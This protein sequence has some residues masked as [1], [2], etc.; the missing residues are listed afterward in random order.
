MAV[1]VLITRHFKEGKGL[2]LLS[3]LIKLRS[4]AVNQMGY[5]TGETLFSSEDRQKML[6]ISTW[7]SEEHWTKWKENAQRK[8][9]EVS[10]EDLLTGPVEYEM[11]AI[12]VYPH[13]S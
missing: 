1:K 10:M 2:E 12:G 5:I 9:A 3:R 6:V 13:N 4:L 11:F 8:E 7:Q